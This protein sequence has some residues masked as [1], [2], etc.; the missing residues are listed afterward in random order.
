MTRLEA[1]PVLEN[2]RVRLRALNRDDAD[3]LFAIFSDP[4]VMRYWSHPPFTREGQVGEYLD[5]I[6]KGLETQRFLQWGLCRAE[7]D[8]VIGTC[9]IWQINH[10]SRRAEIGFALARDHWGKGW[11]TEGLAALLEFAFSGMGLHRLEADVDPGNQASIT[12][13]ERLGFVREGYL[14]ERWVVAGELFDSAFFG[15]LEQDWRSRTR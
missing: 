5:D 13:L 1:L 8:K 4:E 2:G 7:D 11:M 12:L 6:A 3:S 9:T 14:R 10:Q 15:L